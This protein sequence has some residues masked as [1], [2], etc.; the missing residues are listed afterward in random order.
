V[1]RH[2][3]YQTAAESV[4]DMFRRVVQ[5]ATRGDTVPFQL[6][7]NL[8]VF[9][10]A[11]WIEGDVIQ[12]CRLIAVKTET[13][14]ISYFFRA[15]ERQREV[16]YFRLDADSRVGHIFTHP[17]PHVHREPCGEVRYS[18]NGWVSANAVVDFLE[19]LYM[20]LF[21]GEWRAWARRVW[22]AHWPPNHRPVMEIPFD[23]M[24]R[25]AQ[26]S[27]YGVLSQHAAEVHQLKQLLRIRKDELFPLRVSPQRRDLLAYPPA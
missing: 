6:E 26:E 16:S 23:H 8:A 1:S 11:Q 24:M 12:F 14:D 27:N 21:H 2:E 9:G 20:L 22:L 13:C 4:L 15:G 10:V 5:T 19:H 25:A 17:Y 7:E 3:L 18:L